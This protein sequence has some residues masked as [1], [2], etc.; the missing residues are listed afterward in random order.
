[1]DEPPYS[2]LVKEKYGITDRFQTI[3]ERY[4]EIRRDILESKLM[5]EERLN[6]RVRHL[7]YPWFKG[8]RLSVEASKDVGYLCN[9]WGVP[10][11]KEKTRLDMSSFY[12]ARISAEFILTL[13]GRGR[14]PLVGVL[15]NKY[16]NFTLNS[17]LFIFFTHIVNGFNAHI[18]V[19]F[20]SILSCS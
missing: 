19:V 8:S 12:L 1:M 11:S 4:S 13:P 10:T 20:I 16:L 2:Q 18:K 5:I 6:K 15:L 9:Y 7:C 3:G 14:I 17:S